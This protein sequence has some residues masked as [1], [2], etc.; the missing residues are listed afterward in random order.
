MQRALKNGDW[1]PSDTLPGDAPTTAHDLFPYSPVVGALNP[2]SPAAQIWLEDKEEE[3]AVRGTVTFPAQFNGPPE[4]VHG[5]MI[6]ALHDELLGYTGVVLGVGGFTRVLTINYLA[7]TPLDT[8]L[9]LRGRVREIDGRKAWIEGE[10]RHGDTV[11]N[12]SEGLFVRP[13][14]YPVSPG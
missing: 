8:Q 5:G 13:K 6:S 2:V 11:L 9:D 7:L 14:E 4:G 1:V 10:L 12:T 3:W